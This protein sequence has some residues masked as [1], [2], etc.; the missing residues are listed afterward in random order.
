M[1]EAV[2]LYV[3]RLADA[4]VEVEVREFSES[5]HTAGEAATAVGCPV[6]AIVKSL[7]FELDGEPLLVLVSGPNRVDTAALG[8]RLGGTISKADAATV[9]AATG[10]SI[11]AVP[12]IGHPTP[13]HTVMDE[14]L[15][16]LPIVWA[17][18]GSA[19]AVFGIEPDSLALLAG[20]EVLPIG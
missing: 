17:A 2:Q 14:S 16:E 1:Q 19:S 15:L 9:K 4:G 8:E 6:A 5:T 7:V 12:P 18:A 10:Y 20:A 3:S 13:L 11:G